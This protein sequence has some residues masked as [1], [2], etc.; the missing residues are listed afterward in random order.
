M[1][2]W[3]NLIMDTMGALA[4]G[5]ESPAP[6]LLDRRPLRRDASLISR[7][8]IRNIL[9][10]SVFQIALLAYLLLL[11]PGDFACTAG[12]TRHYTILFN[13]FVFCQI[14][15]EFNARSIDDSMDVLRGLHKN[16]TFLAIIL[17]TVVAQVFIV[18][19]GGQFV[20]TEPLELP[21]WVRCVLMASLSLPLGG[22]MRLIPSTESPSSFAVLPALL[23]KQS[24]A[25]DGE[26]STHSSN[27][28]TLS[29]V[30][31][32]LIVAAIPAL[33]YRE[34]NV[35]WSRHFV[36][37]VAA[38]GHH[39]AN[40][41]LPAGLRTVLTALHGALDGLVLLPQ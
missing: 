6:H 17:F 9:I 41:A 39:A 40:Q 27:P 33:V 22:F 34:F 26:K 37:G 8:M 15:N 24:A 13:T 38:L 10:Q 1:M 21:D 31:W 19:F 35:T 20:K 7:P 11:A 30:V 2:L 23:A 32:G 18:Q 4:L 29:L 5:T 3:V 14:F 16:A 25:K 36:A 12:S 28:I